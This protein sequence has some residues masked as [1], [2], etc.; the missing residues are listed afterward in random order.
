MTLA[1]F[2]F[3]GDGGLS[4]QGFGG[5]VREAAVLPFR[6]PG[7]RG[8]GGVIYAGEEGEEEYVEEAW[9]EPRRA[10]LSLVPDL[11]NRSRVRRV[12][13]RRAGRII[14][15]PQLKSSEELSEQEYG[16]S[17]KSPQ[18]DKR[19][20]T[21]KKRA[22]TVWAAAAG[23]YEARK[24][25][26]SRAWKLASDVFRVREE[27]GRRRRETLPY[28]EEVSFRDDGLEDAS[29]R[30]ESLSQGVSSEVRVVLAPVQEKK[31]SFWTGLVIC[32]VSGVT[33]FLFLDHW[34]SRRISSADILVQDERE[35]KKASA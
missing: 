31:G 25:W 33:V 6:S 17:R 14:A 10:V 30:A 15:L 23:A 18:A 34:N 8:S 7:G 29:S 21:K 27:R 26:A 22:S 9:E 3:G 1:A 35:L 2:G 24:K 20:S 32:V 5:E 13:R 19:T 28:F 11:T 12:R 4:T 16:D